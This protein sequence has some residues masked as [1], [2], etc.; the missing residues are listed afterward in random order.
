MIQC[1]R[2]ER[3]TFRIPLKSLVFNLKSN[4]FN[5]TLPK[6]YHFFLELK[7]FLIDSCEEVVARPHI[8]E[9]KYIYLFELFLSSFIVLFNIFL[10]VFFS[11]FLLNKNFK[12]Q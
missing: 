9:L 3:E 5:Y 10:L 12:Q 6:S 11:Y 8:C 2:K 1:V 7:I 4:L